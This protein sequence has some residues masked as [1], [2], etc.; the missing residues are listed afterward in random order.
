MKGI[1]EYP[2]Y[3]A[4]KCPGMSDRA[5]PALAAA[6]VDAPLVERAVKTPSIPAKDNTAF[7]HRAIVADVM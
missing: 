6:E 1:K 2:Y 4:G 5:T 3:P 7:T